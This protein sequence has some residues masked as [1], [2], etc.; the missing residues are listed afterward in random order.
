MEKWNGH[1]E[2]NQ[3]VSCNDAI[4]VIHGRFVCIGDRSVAG[5]IHNRES[6]NTL[7][8]YTLAVSFN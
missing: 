1:K 6:I 7:R 3:K 5:N 2:V 4:R 8:N